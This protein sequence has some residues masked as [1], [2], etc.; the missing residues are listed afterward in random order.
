MGLII[1]KL[2]NFLKCFS[3]FK[4]FKYIIV[5]NRRHLYGQLAFW[6]AGASSSQIINAAALFTH[7]SCNVFCERCACCKPFSRET[8]ECVCSK[9]PVKMAD[10]RHTATYLDT[11]TIQDSLIRYTCTW[12][13][14]APSIDMSF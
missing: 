10:L 2:Q 3:F 4:R 13:Q 11:C 12:M 8:H 6:L 5:P 14:P 7:Q 1:H 9:L